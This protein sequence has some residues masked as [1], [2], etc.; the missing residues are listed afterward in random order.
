MK[1]LRKLLIIGDYFQLFNYPTRKQIIYLYKAAKFEILEQMLTTSINFEY[2]EKEIVLQNVKIVSLFDDIY[3]ELLRESYDPPLILYCKGNLNLLR[4]QKKIALVGSRRPQ[5]YSMEATE[6]IFKDL[7][8][9]NNEEFVI[10][11]GLAAGIDGL[12]HK[13]AITYELPTIAVLGFG[14]NYMYPTENKALYEEICKYG[15]V[16]SEYPPYTSIN[17]WQFVARNRIISG[18]CKVVVVIE[19][20]KKSG[21]L[22][23]AELALSENREVF[24]VGGQSF[25]NAYYGSNQLIQEGAKL[26]LHV[27]EMLEEYKI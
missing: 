22:I 24:I 17:K 20:K 7:I 25:D 4:N 2:S 10:V 9:N 21:S 14:F 5:R 13:L 12:S 26:L 11:S 16:I 18:L 1:K 23:T 6:K 15:L 8:N 27:E 19:A 3:P